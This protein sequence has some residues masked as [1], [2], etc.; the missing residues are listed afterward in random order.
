MASS[1]N[2]HAVTVHCCRLHLSPQ[3]TCQ[4]CC[5]HL[6]IY[7]LTQ[8]FFCKHANS[9]LLSNV[10][11]PLQ[12]ARA[13][14]HPA[15]CCV[16]FA[17]FSHANKQRASLVGCCSLSGNW[18]EEA[19]LEARTGVHRYNKWVATDDLEESVFA[20]KQDS[21]QGMDTFERTLAH[22]NRLVRGCT[23]GNRPWGCC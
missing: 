11:C 13:S 22:D 8:D 6:F 16:C 18:Q 14:P 23:L 19:A 9:M 17:L 4:L 3:W 20:G 15:R 5:I 21:P 12:Q 10:G 1:R 2:P 7:Q